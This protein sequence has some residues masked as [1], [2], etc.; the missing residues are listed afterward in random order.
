M[1]ISL[2]VRRT[3]VV[4]VFDK[5]NEKALLQCVYYFVNISLKGQK[6]NYN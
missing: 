2:F 6:L 1:A 3:N 5:I 4:R